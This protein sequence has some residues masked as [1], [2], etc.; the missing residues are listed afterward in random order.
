MDPTLVLAATLNGAADLLAG[1]GAWMRG[2]FAA[3]ATGRVIGPEERPAVCWCL[4][5][6]L[7]RSAPNTGAAIRDGVLERAHDAVGEVIGTFDLAGWNDAPGRTQAEVVAAL[8][9]SAE[10][11]S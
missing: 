4:A 5:G 9:Q 8:R 3:T 7:M 10:A 6:A 11:C 2:A 1:P